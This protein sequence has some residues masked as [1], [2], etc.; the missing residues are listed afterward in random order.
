[1]RLPCHIC[2]FADDSIL[3]ARATVQES[4]R[5]A[6][7]I[8]TYERASGQRVNFDKTEISFSKG[9]PQL[10]RQQI[11][12]LFGV[13]EVERHSKYLGLPTILGRSKKAVFACLKERI[14][15]K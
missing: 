15:K 11:K 13:S 12:E 5:V 14:W 4:S 8:S 1:M 9:V 2:F 7:I 3:F 10:L 6:N